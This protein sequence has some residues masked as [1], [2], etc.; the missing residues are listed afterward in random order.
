MS[1][2]T[3]RLMMKKKAIGFPLTET[4]RASSKNKRANK[5]RNKHIL[6]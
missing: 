1:L 5:Q 4:V 3:L 2:S 6:N